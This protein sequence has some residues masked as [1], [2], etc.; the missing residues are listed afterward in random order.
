M[1]LDAS[2]AK[3]RRSGKDFFAAWDE[4]SLQWRDENAQRFTRDFVTRLQAELRSAELALEHMETILRQQR[5][6]CT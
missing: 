2:Y 5:Q 1:S 3:L 4:V 6:D